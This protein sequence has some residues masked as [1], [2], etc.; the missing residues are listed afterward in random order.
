MNEEQHKTLNKVNNL[1]EQLCFDHGQQQFY[2]TIT[3]TYKRKKI[4]VDITSEYNN[5]DYVYVKP[6]VSGSKPFE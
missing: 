1:L 6:G 2:T 3:N 5:T 4:D